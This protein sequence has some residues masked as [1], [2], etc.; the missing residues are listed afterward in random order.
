M[1]SHCE[2]K[3]VGEGKEDLA[4]PSAFCSSV[5]GGALTSIWHGC[6]SVVLWTYNNGTTVSKLRTVRTKTAVSLCRM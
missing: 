4:A 5:G 2:E 1:G 6:C 3:P